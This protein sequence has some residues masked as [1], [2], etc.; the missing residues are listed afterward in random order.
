MEEKRPR[1]PTAFQKAMKWLKPIYIA[2][3]LF[4]LARYLFQNYEAIRALQIS[5]DWPVLA[6]SMVT[7]LLYK[8]T[9]AWLFHYITRLDRCDIPVREALPGILYSVLGQN[10]SPK[11]FYVGRP[12]SLLSTPPE[13]PSAMSRFV[14]SLKTDAPCW[15]QPSSFLLLCSSSPTISLHSTNLSSWRSSRCSLS[16]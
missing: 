5:L 13:T 14:F 8:L 7:Y 2:A 9:L 1:T 16:A 15:V 3:A 4:F 10:T 6:L 12:V 11:V